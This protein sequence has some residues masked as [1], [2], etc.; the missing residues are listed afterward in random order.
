MWAV[1]D[2]NLYYRQWNK[3]IP[4]SMNGLVG[5]R[6]DRLLIN[7]LIEKSNI[8]VLR[9]GGRSDSS[10]LSTSE[11][12]RVHRESRIGINSNQFEHAPQVKGRV[13][14]IIAS[15][16]ML[17]ELT[18]PAM[19][20]FFKKDLEYVEFTYDNFIGKMQYYLKNP[21]TVD[22]IAHAGY[23]KFMNNYT[24]RHYWERVFSEI[25]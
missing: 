23:C 24:N 25:S 22:K 1:P 14:E 15:N 17:M 8:P 2:P 21:N 10:A 6:K 4:I 12:A 5:T 7:S 16:T 9:V 20:G 3:P 19:G 11:Y 18:N 13:M